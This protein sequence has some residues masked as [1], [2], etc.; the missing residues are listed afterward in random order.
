MSTLFSLARCC[1]TLQCNAQHHRSSCLTTL[2][3]VTVKLVIAAPSFSSRV[4]AYLAMLLCHA[5][6]GPS[7][8]CRQNQSIELLCCCFSVGNPGRCSRSPCCSKFAGHSGFCSGPRALNEVNGA[9]RLRHEEAEEAMDQLQRLPSGSVP[10]DALC[11][12]LA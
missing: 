8:P 5:A 1:T 10:V 4:H 3:Q 2:C 6:K 11:C 9:A 7:K 12:S